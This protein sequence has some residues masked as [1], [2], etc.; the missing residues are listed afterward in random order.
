MISKGKRTAV[1]TVKEHDSVNA[2][3]WFFSSH[4]ISDTTN[5]KGDNWNWCIMPTYTKYHLRSHMIGG[6]TVAKR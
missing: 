6:G 4:Y 1:K 5:I 3:C 2:K